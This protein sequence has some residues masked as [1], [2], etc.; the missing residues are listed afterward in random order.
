MAHRT[1]LL[2]AAVLGL[3]GSTVERLEAQKCPKGGN[4]LVPVTAEFRCP[5]PVCLAIDQIQGDG[6][7]PYRGVTP[8]GCATTQEGLATTEGGYLT[9]GNLF[10][11]S[12]KAGLGR[13]VSLSFTSSLGTAPCA[14]SRTCR[15]NFDWAST[16]VSVPG[17]HTYPVD[18]MGTDLPNGLMSIPVGQS[19][20]A[21]WFFNFDDPAGRS[22]LWT[23]RFDPRL[24]PGSTYLTVTRLADA[25]WS[26]SASDANIAQLVSDTTS[27]KSA[28]VN[29]GYYSM[30]FRILVTR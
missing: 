9:E 3:A 8:S 16:D 2:L 7:G 24:Y 23:V 5:G 19:A 30:P 6:V 29:E 20:P 28:K 22:I 18:A 13:F 4:T 12:L 21:R 25:Q 27:G 10:L 17:S 1:V 14:P 26:I 11:F 15:K